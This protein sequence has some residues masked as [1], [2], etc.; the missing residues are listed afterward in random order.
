MGCCFS[1]QTYYCYIRRK[2]E[3]CPNGCTW[4]TYDIVQGD[5][6][7]LCPHESIQ[8]YS[9]VEHVPSNEE[10]EEVLKRWENLELKDLNRRLWVLETR[11][12]VPTK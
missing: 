10:P 2:V 6:L 7:Y 11:P 4:R 8:S 9:L 12:I 5:R 3:I 1:E